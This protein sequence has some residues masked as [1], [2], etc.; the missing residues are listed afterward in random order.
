MSDKQTNN[1]NTRTKATSTT[2]RDLHNHTD[3]F[4]SSS[5][6]QNRPSEITMESDFHYFPDVVAS[7]TSI[8]APA[9]KLYVFL[10][11]MSDIN[12]GET[13]PI[14]VAQL[15]EQFHRHK[16]TVQQ[17]LKELV[18]LG[19]IIRVFRKNKDNPKQNEASYFI[20]THVRDANSCAKNK[21]QVR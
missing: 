16:R 13:P 20:I 19:L 7:N 12:T 4:V 15:A 14:Y 21:G 8:P 11:N 1:S 18:D 17:W 10:L 6:M 2:N 5:A 9:L 3:I